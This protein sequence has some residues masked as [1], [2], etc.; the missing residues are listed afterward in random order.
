METLVFNRPQGKQRYPGHRGWQSQTA[1]AL[2]P[3]SSTALG[4]KDVLGGEGLNLT[5]TPAST[6]T[7]AFCSKAAPPTPSWPHAGLCLQLE[8][9]E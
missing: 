7:E 4:G 8:G 1:A 5:A 6:S 9:E 3:A 2:Q